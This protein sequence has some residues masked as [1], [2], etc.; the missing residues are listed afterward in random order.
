M[1]EKKVTHSPLLIAGHHA[2]GGA[3]ALHGEL[4]DGHGL[5]SRAVHDVGELGGRGEEAG[6]V[7]LQLAVLH[8]EAELDSEE[9]ALG[10]KSMKVNQVGMK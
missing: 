5:L 4:V 1:S 2:L 3:R 8:A 6:A 7:R 10:R 9:V